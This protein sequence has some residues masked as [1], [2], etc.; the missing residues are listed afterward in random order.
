[1]T[2]EEKYKRGYELL[3][4]FWWSVP[5]SDETFDNM[6]FEL[7]DEISEITAKKSKRSKK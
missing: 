1:M 6:S 4:E 7:A 5:L 3:C 2:K